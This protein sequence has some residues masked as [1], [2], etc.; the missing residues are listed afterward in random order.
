VKGSTPAQRRRLR[1]TLVTRADRVLEAPG[2]TPEFAGSGA[3]AVVLLSA[4][5]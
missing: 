2:R 5:R 4:I 3:T 1:S